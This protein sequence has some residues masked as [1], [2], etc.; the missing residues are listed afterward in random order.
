MSAKNTHNI[1]R[2]I[3]APLLAIALFAAAMALATSPFAVFSLPFWMPGLVIAK[4]LE[5]VNLFGD[6][7]EAYQNTRDIIN[8]GW[9]CMLMYF[10]PKF[11]AKFRDRKST[12][13]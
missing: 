10:V 13:A 7:F 1:L 2:F 4:G 3:A 12:Q 5:G 6:S 9:I 11:V 8:F